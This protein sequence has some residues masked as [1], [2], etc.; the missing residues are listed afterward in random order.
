MPRK[1]PPARELPA[2]PPELLDQLV[3]EPNRCGRSGGNGN[4][5]QEGAVLTDL[6]RQQRVAP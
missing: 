3:S 5:V 2:I 4:G 6:G 1:K